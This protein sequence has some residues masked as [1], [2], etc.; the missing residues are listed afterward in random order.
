MSTALVF[1]ENA[2]VTVDL[3]AA[4]LCVWWIDVLSYEEERY[5]VST[6]YLLLP[7]EFSKIANESWGTW[8]F[9]GI[10]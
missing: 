4:L 7:T 9:L 10:W 2:S 1:P 5:L 8:L 3:P 6:I